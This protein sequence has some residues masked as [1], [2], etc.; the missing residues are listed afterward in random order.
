MTVAIDAYPEHPLVSSRNGAQLLEDGYRLESS[1]TGLYRN[2]HE[3]D[4]KLYDSMATG[5][6]IA[7]RFAELSRN[8]VKFSVFRRLS[9]GLALFAA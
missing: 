7:A 1:T 9:W 8:L 6:N 2:I 3:W 5:E 4:V